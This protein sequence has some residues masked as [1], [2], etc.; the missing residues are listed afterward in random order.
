MDQSDTFITIGKSFPE[1]KRA[2]RL[3][4]EERGVAKEAEMIIRD[5]MREVDRIE[6]LEAANKE[7]Q[8]SGKRLPKELKKNLSEKYHFSEKDI[9]RLVYSNSGD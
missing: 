7:Y 3:I 4:A 5:I 9:E 1:L 2:A 6:I 8:K